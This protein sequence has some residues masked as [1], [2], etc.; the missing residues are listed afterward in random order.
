MLMCNPE[1]EE[2]EERISKERQ[3]SEIE[4]RKEKTGC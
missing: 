1:K 2:R 3:E 4:N